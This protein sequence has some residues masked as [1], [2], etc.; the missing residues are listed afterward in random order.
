M[1]INETGLRRSG[2]QLE[3]RTTGSDPIGGPSRDHPVA[4]PFP[5]WTDKP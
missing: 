1:E 4:N 2:W 5:T 3:A